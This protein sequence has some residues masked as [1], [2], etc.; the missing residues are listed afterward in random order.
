MSDKI[1]P[2]QSPTA[3]AFL[4]AQSL[5]F[6]A[7][8]AV[9]IIVSFALL[10][11]GHSALDVGKVL[12]ATDL[13]FV[14]LLLVGGAV[15]D[16]FSRKIV[17]VSSEFVRAF[18][19]GSM[20]YVVSHRSFGTFELGAFGALWGSARAFFAPT[21][22]G[23]TPEIFAQ[24]GLVAANA[25]REGGRSI[26][27]LVGPAF[28][29]ISIVTLGPS[30]TLLICALIYCI[31]G[32]WLIRMR[33]GQSRSLVSSSFM[34]DLKTG[35]HEVRSQSWCW[36]TIVVYAA[37]H[38][39]VFGPFFVL[40][41][42]IVKAHLGGAAIWGTLVAF[43]GVG[44]I[45]GATAASKI[46]LRRPIWSS[47]L[48]AVAGAPSFFLLALHAPSIIIGVSIVAFGVG[49]AFF[50]VNWETA[51]QS[52]FPIEAMSRISAFDIFGSVALLPAG[53][54]L[55]GLS[56]QFVSPTVA[57]SLSGVAFVVLSIALLAIRPIW[58]LEAPSRGE[59]QNR[60][61]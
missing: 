8:A 46:K 55:G 34:R 9:P 49:F 17:A 3:R 50:G 60:D 38:L 23:M 5:S 20:A 45:V 22:T 41:P 25:Y 10:D 61:K 16:R 15:A 37:M 26:G 2:L 52:H 4:G 33:L 36:V 19:L 7:S 35:F 39:L 53:Q 59:N 42:V 48:I 18:A 1:R 54:I 6:L 47:S 28:A 24:D 12:A 14:L 27:N 13:P 11:S 44:G 29:G 58:R 30:K 51:L 56:T 32:T 57:L 31:S 43:E 40:G 21:L